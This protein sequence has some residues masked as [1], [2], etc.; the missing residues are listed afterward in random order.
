MY[1]CKSDTAS[2]SSTGR[3]SD[4][5]M[6]VTS[7][8]ERSTT[9]AV[10]YGCT[11]KIMKLTSAWLQQFAGQAL[12]PLV[13]PMIFAELERKRLLDML[14]AEQ[15]ALRQRILD[16]E[17]KL[18]G[19]VRTKESP[20]KTREKCLDKAQEDV[21]LQ[22]QDCESTK[23]WIDVS[24]LRNGLE[25]LKAELERMAAHSRDLAETVLIEQAE[26]RKTG[27]R[28]EARLHD[29]V[30]E[31]NSKVRSCE[32]LLG[33]MALSAQMVRTLSAHAVFLRPFYC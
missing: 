14:D 17:N 7:F 5:A 10:M 32:S 1:N 8:V 2:P 20:G 9:Y 11:E 22:V 23:L 26:K 13:M 25:S 33:G 28:I 29:M 21:L 3:P 31:I 15:T 16:L 19:E 18:R 12:H 24:S 30:A 27:N 6:S 4:I